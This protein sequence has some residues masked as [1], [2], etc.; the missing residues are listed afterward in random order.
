[1]DQHCL[2]NLKFRSLYYLLIL[3]Q[4]CQGSSHKSIVFSVTFFFF[5][6][7]YKTVVNKIRIKEMKRQSVTERHLPY[8]FFRTVCY[9]WQ[10]KFISSSFHRER[11]YLLNSEKYSYVMSIF[12]I[13]QGR[14]MMDNVSK[15]SSMRK[16]RLYLNESPLDISVIR[17]LVA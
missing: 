5:L 1:M 13:M 10:I 14:A 9:Q 4:Q 7:T 8:L 15:H 16:R 11:Q 12:L 2:Q 3:L 17:S 6:M